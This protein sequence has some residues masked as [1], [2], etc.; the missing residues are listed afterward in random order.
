MSEARP[1]RS[2][3]L[4]A[5]GTRYHHKIGLRGDGSIPSPSMAKVSPSFG[6][7]L[8]PNFQKLFSKEKDMH[9]KYLKCCRFPLDPEVF[10][11]KF[12]GTEAMGLTR[13]EVEAAMVLETAAAIQDVPGP[14]AQEIVREHLPPWLR[15]RFDD[16]L[17]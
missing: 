16:R 1:K 4:C 14:D 10:E 2:L 11:E 12:D 7:P 13:A 17:V 3:G 9:P 8:R 15:G 5:P 6:G